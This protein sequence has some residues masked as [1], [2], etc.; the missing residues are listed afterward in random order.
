MKNVRLLSVLALIGLLVVSCATLKPTHRVK[1][2]FDEIVA[3]QLNTPKKVSKWL[4]YHF[5]YD[6]DKNR[7]DRNGF[8]AIY[9]PWET[10][11]E[12]SGV[13]YDSANFAGYCLSKAGYKCEMVYARAFPGR[14]GH[15]VCAFKENGSW[16]VVGDTRNF[17]VD[18]PYR[19]FKEI[20][21]RI[22]RGVHGNYR[23]NK[24]R[25]YW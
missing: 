10:Y 22:T 19:D 3:T 13:C 9:A 23:L 11:Q 5:T 8:I 1:A 2:E 15:V 20:A 12:K 18:G 6:H 4:W 24:Y 25:K 17:S 16:W 7:R 14:S 21:F